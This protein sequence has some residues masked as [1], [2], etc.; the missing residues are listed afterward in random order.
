MVATIETMPIVYS[1]EGNHWYVSMGE[2][3]QLAVH[4]QAYYEEISRIHFLDLS[5]M[6]L[7]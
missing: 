7:N 5:C 4:G 2:S 6:K 3:Q 1:N